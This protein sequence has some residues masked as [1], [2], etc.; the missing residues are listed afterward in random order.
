MTTATARDDPSNMDRNRL[1][2][3]EA[4]TTGILSCLPS[5]W[6]PYAE[7]MR[8]H[9][10]TGILNIYFPYLFGGLYASWI[11]RVDLP[12]LLARSA[13][14]LAAAFVLRSA[15]CSWNDIVDRD[16]DRQ[17][18]R[19]RLRPM[20]RGAIPVQSAVV[21]TAMQSAVWLATLSLVIP[22]HWAY[23]LPLIGLVMFYPFAKR[24]T[25]HAQVVLGLP[26]AC[27]VLIGSSA[28]GV[29]PIA[30]FLSQKAY[31]AGLAALFF[32]YILWSVI[33]DTV[34]AQ[35][36]VEDDMKAGVKSMAVH[37]RYYLKPLLLILG[38]IQVAL[39]IYM[40]VVLHADIPYQMLT[41]AG[42][43]TLIVW[44]LWSVDLDDPQSCGEWFQKGCV[45]LGVIVSSGL[46]AEYLLRRPF[47]SVATFQ[48]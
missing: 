38:V 4:P 1:P 9:K 41:S 12:L 34:Y 26:L 16:V 36:D 10:P 30:T 11:S 29:D 43:A 45:A 40:G 33:H 35:Q 20:A 32:S 24:V 37:Y 5:A 6:V 42:S 3:Y 28:L 22:S 14:L 39:Y 17:V 44:M 46:F 8:L 31:S 27:G 18:A 48:L 21:F 19:C 25:H 13:V 23:T 15:G 47:T 2:V 7:L